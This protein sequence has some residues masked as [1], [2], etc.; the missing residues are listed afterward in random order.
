L[1]P[2]IV[3]ISESLCALFRAKVWKDGNAGN[4]LGSR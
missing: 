1:C 2:Q 3:E 4:G